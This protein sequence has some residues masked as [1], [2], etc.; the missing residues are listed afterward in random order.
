MPLIHSI[1]CRNVWLSMIGTEWLEWRLTGKPAAFS[2]IQGGW[3]VSKVASHLWRRLLGWKG[4]GGLV[5]LQTATELSVQNGQGEWQVV[6]GRGWWLGRAAGGKGGSLCQ[7]INE[8]IFL[9]ICVM[10]HRLN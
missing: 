6:A 10:M 9:L 8:C 3:P 5:L 7:A 1:Q 2:I 4:G